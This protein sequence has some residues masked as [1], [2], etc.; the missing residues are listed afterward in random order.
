VPPLKVSFPGVLL[1]LRH[2]AL[3]GL[4]GLGDFLRADSHPYPGAT[5]AFNRCRSSADNSSARGRIPC[6]RSEN[7]FAVQAPCDHIAT[8]QGRVWVRASNV[9]LSVID[10]KTNRVTERFG[11]SSGSGAVRVAGDLVWVTAHDIQHVWVLRP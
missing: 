6:G 5:I 9:L 2:E 3:A 10:A 4:P 7:G 8:G 1:H 11:P